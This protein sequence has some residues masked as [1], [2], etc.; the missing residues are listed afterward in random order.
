M[1]IEERVSALESEVAVI[2]QEAAAARALAAGADRDVADYRAE[3]R[4][5][6]RLLNALRETQVEQAADI[7]GMKTDINEMRA[8]INEMKTDINEMRA[9]ISG[10]KTDINGIKTVQEEHGSALGEL[11]TGMTHIIGLLDELIRRE[12]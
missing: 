9:D 6:T 1:S 7:S 8:D 10:T 12:G 2:R 4:S 11:R 3:M 5:Q